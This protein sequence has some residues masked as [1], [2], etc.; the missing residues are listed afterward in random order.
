M[1]KVTKKR[2]HKL[3]FWVFNA[4]SIIIMVLPPF[5]GLDQ[6]AM[7]YLGAFTW[8]ILM[9]M[10][11]VLPQFIVP[12]IILLVLIITGI[13]DFETVFAP[14]SSSTIWS[15]VGVFGLSVAIAK[16]GAL[17]RLVL[18][19]L[20][21]FPETFNGQILAMYVTNLIL[22]PLIPSAI[23][24]LAILS[25][26]ALNMSERYGYKKSSK[27]AIGIFGG[28]YISA[29]IF[30]HAFL[31]GAAAVG[32]MIGFMDHGITSFNFFTWLS[33][34]FVWLV[35]MFIGS[36]LFI[37]MY[38]NPKLEQKIKKGVIQSEIKKLQPI[39]RHEIVTWLIM[40]TAVIM[41]MSEGFHGISTTIVVLVALCLFV[42]SGVLTP[43]D[44]NQK[45]DW[46]TIILL[47]A[48]FGVASFM[49]P[50]G[51]TDWLAN[52]LGHFV[53]PFM[54]NQYVF[55]FVICLLTFI[56]RFFFI[57][58]I[59]LLSLFTAV[60]GA[61]AESVGISSFVLVYVVY[62]VAQD[63]NTPFNNLAIITTLSTTEHKLA[64]YNDTYVINLVYFALNVFGFLASVPVW[65]MFGFIE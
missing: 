65:K 19:L 41:W 9:M 55:V 48:I 24:K 36:Y 59:V 22:A 42:V 63:W 54:R 52:G 40:G 7:I 23:G 25:P 45:I 14:F 37:I 34:T 10:I 51:V 4:V 58:S 33:G 28:L 32:I 53:G 56:A 1:R 3:L 57:S 15:I 64:D 21:P 12:V 8:M 61:F 17:N 11:P 27:G 44:F 13:G 39:S 18:Y 49:S 6:R 60:F 38:Y 43:S 26:L 31:T 50:L 20:R 47:G 35:I 16:S 29:G 5:D 30:G 2:S 62:L 46:K